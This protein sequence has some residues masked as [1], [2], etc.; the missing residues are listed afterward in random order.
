MKVSL[1]YST[2]SKQ[3]RKELKKGLLIAIPIILMLVGLAYS[4]QYLQKDGYEFYS[5]QIKHANN[6]PELA[7][8][9]NGGSQS[10]LNGLA[11]G[12]QMIYTDKQKEELKV[13]VKQK[14][15]LC[16]SWQNVRDKNGNSSPELL[17]CEQLSLV[18][19]Y[20]ENIFEQNSL[21][22]TYHKKGCGLNHD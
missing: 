11:L 6:C 7:L 17:S 21:E 9:L 5:N 14:L 8:A 22:K 4:F 2:N 15:S 16:D 19:G 20:T 12:Y 18:I 13:L 3:K 10:I 1:S